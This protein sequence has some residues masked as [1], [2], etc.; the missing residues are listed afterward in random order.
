M[1]NKSDIYVFLPAFNEAKVIGNLIASLHH[2]GYKNVCVIDDGSTDDTGKIALEA[3]TKVIRHL[4]NRGVGAATQTAIEYAKLKNLNYIVLMDAD[5]QHLPQDIETMIDCMQKQ[6]ADL[7][8]GSRFLKDSSA[9]PRTR[10]KY[11]YLANILTNLFCLNNYTDTQSGF[12]MLNKQAINQ[13]NLLLDD[14]GFCSEMII[15]AEK[16]GL[17]IKEVP[18]EVVYTSYSL[19]KGQNLFKGIRTG[20]SLLE[21]ILFK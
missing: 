15:H 17:R 3:K 14:Y 8:L 13:L 21:R 6:E 11:N 20:L 7:I 5:G 16:L 19:S 1:I 4:V 18:V 2:N 9:M 12:R 10:K